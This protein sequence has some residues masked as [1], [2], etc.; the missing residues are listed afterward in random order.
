MRNRKILPPISLLLFFFGIAICAGMLLLHSPIS[1]A[2]EKISWID[3]LFTAT[4]AVCVT[5]LTVVDAGAS[6]SR[7]V[8]TVI[9]F[10][11]QAGGLGIMTFASLTFYLWRHQLSLTDRIA[12]GQSLLYDQSFSLGSFF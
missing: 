1:F 2:G 11:I 12:V 5:G 3:A 10:L 7:F 6:F 4:S 9:L 8:Q